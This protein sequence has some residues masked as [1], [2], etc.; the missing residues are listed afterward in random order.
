[1]WPGHHEKKKDNITIT[2]WDL[3]VRLAAWSIGVKIVSEGLFE[4]GY[5]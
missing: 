1:M 3:S 5:M 4:Q 2:A